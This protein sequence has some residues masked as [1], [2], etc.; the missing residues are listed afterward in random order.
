MGAVDITERSRERHGVKIDNNKVHEVYWNL[1]ANSIDMRNSR[2][3]SSVYCWRIT[4]L[5]KM[6][7]KKEE[8]NFGLGY[9]EE[10]VL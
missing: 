8:R 4:W 2:K 3:N 1:P 9:Y 6:I 10:Y 5:E 7:I